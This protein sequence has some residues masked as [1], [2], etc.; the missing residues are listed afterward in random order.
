MIR[1]LPSWIFSLPNFL[2]SYGGQRRSERSYLARKKEAEKRNQIHLSQLDKSSAIVKEWRGAHYYVHIE[3]SPNRD[4]MQFAIDWRGHQIRPS[5]V[6]KDDD[7][8]IYCRYATTLVTSEVFNPEQEARE[9]YMTVILPDT[10]FISRF[11]IELGGQLF[12]AYVREKENAW[13]EYQE[14]V[15][16]GKTAGKKV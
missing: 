14:A 9:I 6:K 1:S 7:E 13:R 16:Q 8:I 15:S 5:A 2:K 12:V 10:A 11:A 3:L 4:K